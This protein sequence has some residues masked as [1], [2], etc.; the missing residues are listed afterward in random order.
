MDKFIL[1]ATY[2]NYN[3]GSLLQCYALQQF[4]KLQDIDCYLVKREYG[5][6]ERICIALRNR[7]DYYM[8]SLKYPDII[9]ENKRQRQSSKSSV[10]SISD[11]S[12]N[13]IEEFISNN[14][15]VKKATY[16]LLKSLSRKDNCLFCVAGSDQI[17]NGSRIFIEPLY[18]LSFAPKN[19]RVAISPSFGGSK[20]KNY[21]VNRYRKYINAFTKLSVREDSGKEII[22]ELTGKDSLQLLDPVFLLTKN[23]WESMITESR[24]R[25]NKYVLAFFLDSPNENAI[26][27][28][29]QYSKMGYSVV[30]IGY[31][32]KSIQDLE[33]YL[34]LEGGPLD[35]VDAISKAEVVCTDSFHATAFSVLLHKE[36]YSYHRNYQAQDQS[37]RLTSF[38]ESIDLLYRYDYEGILDEKTDFSKADVLIDENSKNIRKYLEI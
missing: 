32:H 19:K 12:A 13:L 28:L 20:V 2:C 6:F 25:V 18:F 7:I 33:N 22:K 10:D 5:S 38:L 23:E 36:F 31:K 9:K 11:T 24:I 3:Y 1:Q 37:T 30:E 34:Y 29:A 27:T 21:N 26:N 16:R 8:L 17:W 35:F 4:F 14:I 15:Y